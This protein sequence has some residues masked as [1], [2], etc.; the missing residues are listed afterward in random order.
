MQTRAGRPPLEAEVYRQVAVRTL[1]PQGGN[2]AARQA[3]LSMLP[4]GGWRETD[5]VEVWLPPEK[6]ERVD[7]DKVSEDITEGLP[8][9][10]HYKRLR[11]YRHGR[12][13]GQEGAVCDVTLL[14]CCHGLFKPAYEL[15]ASR[16][17][18]RGRS[19]APALVD[20]AAEA[21]AVAGLAM[22]ADQEAGEEL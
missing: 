5:E 7:L 15:W 18:A 9:A 3:V 12:W 16:S 14:Q 1:L 13:L 10:L 21:L 8:A 22:L 20:P 19:R 4:K 17:T 6:F 2:F 11:M